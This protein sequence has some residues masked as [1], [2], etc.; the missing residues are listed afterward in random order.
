VVKLSALD[1]K[2][3]RDVWDTRG[4]ALAIAMVIASGVCMF[5]MYL[6]NFDSLR[7]TQSAYYE[8]QRFGDVF[9]GLKRAPQRVEARIAGIPGVATVQTRVVVGVTL[10][11]EG[12][13]EP[14][15]GRLVSIPA[16]GRPRLNDVFLRRGR[17]IEE[18]L[19]LLMRPKP[20]F[21]LARLRT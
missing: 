7:R 1:R 2:L 8:R 4:Q 17:W 16:A 19:A 10:D 13:P 6:S 14:A 21:C 15:S 18:R 3:L 12:M 20:A 11:V 9:A 5:V